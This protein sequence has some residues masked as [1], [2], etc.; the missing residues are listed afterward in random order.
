MI[1]LAPKLSDSVLNNQLLKH[2]AKCQLDEQ[3]SIRT[4]VNI[5]L[6]KIAKHLSPAV[7]IVVDVASIAWVGEQLATYRCPSLKK[8]RM[9]N[10]NEAKHDHACDDVQ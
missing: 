4:N 1:L 10:E 5:C 2:F 8:L 6:G 7:S 9:G 3:P